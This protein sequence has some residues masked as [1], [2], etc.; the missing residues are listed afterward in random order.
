MASSASLRSV[1][2]LVLAAMVIGA[3][4]KVESQNVVAARAGVAGNRRR[5]ISSRNFT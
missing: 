5:P 4:A 2:T 3:G 1:E